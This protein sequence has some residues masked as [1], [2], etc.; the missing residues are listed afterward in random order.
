MDNMPNSIRSETEDTPRST[1]PYI[2]NGSYLSKPYAEYAVCQK[3][4]IEKSRLAFLKDCRINKRPPPSLRVR[5][6]TAISDIVKL[7]QFSAIESNL[8]QN[9]IT[10]KTELI[11]KLRNDCISDKRMPLPSCDC[12]KMKAYLTRSLSFIKNK[13]CPNGA[14]GLRNVLLISGHL[15]RK[16]Q[17]R[18]LN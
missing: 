9:A 15:R 13:M 7:P 3:L 5:G 12:Y 17:L 18:T 16:I 8:L 4:E 6:A 2:E 11:N 1:V 10:L 14:I